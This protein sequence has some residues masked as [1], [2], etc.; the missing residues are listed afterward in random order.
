M[1]EIT[2]IL[3]DITKFQCD[4]IVNSAHPSLLGKGGVDAAIHKAAGQELT[5]ECRSLHGC[6]VGKAKITKAYKLPARY[7]I[8]T[9]GPSWQGGNNHEMELLASCYHS[10]LLLAEKYECRAIAFPSIGTGIYHFPIGLAAETAVSTVL[11]FYMDHN[12]PLKITFV[13]FDLETQMHYQEAL[14]RQ[15]VNR[16]VWLCTASN[17]DKPAHGGERPFIGLTSSIALNLTRWEGFGKYGDFIERSGRAID[18]NIRNGETLDLN[19]CVATLI[20]IHREQY[21]NGGR[22]DVITP[23]IMDGGITKMAERIRE[24]HHAAERIAD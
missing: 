11:D 7:V 23:R 22:S 21:W 1:F 16:L 17:W 13:C 19:T 10:S 2:T 5:D 15:L 6:D 8:H 9:P 14:N 4:A 18:Q 12:T 3:G 20:C 24:L